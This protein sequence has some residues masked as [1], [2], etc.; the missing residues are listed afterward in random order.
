MIIL[1]VEYIPVHTVY[2]TYKLP[3]DNAMNVEEHELDMNI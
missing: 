2:V 1:T 3:H